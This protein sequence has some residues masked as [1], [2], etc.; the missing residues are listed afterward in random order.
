MDVERP[1]RYVDFVI[2]HPHDECTNTYHTKCVS[3]SRR[4][5][6]LPEYLLK[7]TLLRYKNEMI[8]LQNYYSYYQIMESCDYQLQFCSEGNKKFFLNILKEI[9]RHDDYLSN[10]KVD[11]VQCLTI[12]KAKAKGWRVTTRL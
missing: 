11:R 7:D 10:Y 8:K 6:S 12:S 3:K 1:L 4:T 2:A 9:F 5:Y